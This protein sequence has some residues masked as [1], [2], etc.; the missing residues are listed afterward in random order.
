MKHVLLASTALMMVAGTASAEVA[1]SGTAR[2][3]IIADFGDTDAAFTSRVRIIFTASGETD[4]GLAFGATVRNDQSGVGNTA[5]GDSVVYLSGA[6]G[7]FSMGDVDGAAGAAVGQV[8]GVGLTGLGDMN[9]V[10]YLANGGTDFNGNGTIN[11]DDP[12]DTSVLYEYSIGDFSLYASSSQPNLGVGAHG[13]AVAG[14]YSMGNYTFALGYENLDAEDDYVWEQFVLGAT[15]T[16][17]AVAVKAVVAD[18][19][20]NQSES[21]QQY[22]LSVTYT[23]NALSLTAFAA[24]DDEILALDIAGGGNAEAYGLGA[25]YDL[26]GGAKVMGGYVTNQ[27]TGDDAFDLGLSLSF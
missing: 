10:T 27:T 17:G 6:F 1:I 25:S 24:N 20:N 21:W 22:A 4:G 13:L 11:L 2:M 7:K 12:N 3:G 9:E 14:K 26:G 15:A 8:D 16:F 5:N 19:S 18:G 23:A